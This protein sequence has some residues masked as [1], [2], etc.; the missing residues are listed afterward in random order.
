M[1][2]TIIAVSSIRAKG[3]ALLFLMHRIKISYSPD[4]IKVNPDML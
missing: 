1:H 4:Y 2:D 3:I